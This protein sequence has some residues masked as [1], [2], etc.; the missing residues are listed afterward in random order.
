MR[1]AFRPDALFGRCPVWPMPGLAYARFGLCRIVPHL[2][3]TRLYIISIDPM[4]AG[5]PATFQFSILA[6]LS[7]EPLLYGF[8]VLKPGY[9][10]IL[11]GNC[12][13][14]DDRTLVSPP[15]DLSPIL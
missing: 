9:S 14:P 3:E 15:I 4:Q 8:L 1:Y 2:F 11:M 7:K 12:S 6:L 13:Q 5:V 10:D